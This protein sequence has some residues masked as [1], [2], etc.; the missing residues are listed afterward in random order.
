MFSSTT[1][2]TRIHVN[3]YIHVDS[4]LSNTFHT[5]AT[6]ACTATTLTAASQAFPS[7]TKWLPSTQTVR[8]P[9]PSLTCAC[10]PTSVCHLTRKCMLVNMQAH[11]RRALQWRDLA[12]ESGPPTTAALLLVAFVFIGGLGLGLVQCT[13]VAM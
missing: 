1:C 13:E 6:A 11:I 5:C 7:S 3:L 2:A 12:S 10:P 8:S 4:V 9:P